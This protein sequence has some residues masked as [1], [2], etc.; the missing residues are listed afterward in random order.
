MKM[1]WPTDAAVIADL[2]SLQRAEFQAVLKSEH[3]AEILYRVLWVK[4]YCDAVGSSVAKFLEWAPG[5]SQGNPRETGEVPRWKQFERAR[6]LVKV[7]MR[8]E[9]FVK[10][11]WFSPA[12]WYRERLECGHSLNVPASFYGDPPP[13]R[14][15]CKQCA[16]E[17]L[18]RKQP[19]TERL[20]T[21]RNGTGG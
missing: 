3:D 10:A 18:A 12:T 17:R 11:K 1:P 20:Q 4:R 15:R 7:V 13:K 19:G 2:E 14:R 8:E 6:P 5:P 16:A 9:Y 21:G